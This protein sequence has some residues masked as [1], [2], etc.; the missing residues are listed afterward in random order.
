[1]RHAHANFLNPIGRTFV[2]N[3]IE[4][5]HQRFRALERK[6]LL[7]D[8]TRVQKNFERLGFHQR[9]QQR[10]FHM[11]RRR[12]FIGARFEPVQHPI[13]HPRVLNVHELSAD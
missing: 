2:Q 8:V 11:S 3:T 5:H 6:A 4:N 13:P 1:M 7:P 10:N 9:A 12:M